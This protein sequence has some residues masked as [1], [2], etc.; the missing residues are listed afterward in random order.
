M[1]RSI[2]ALVAL[3]LT[4]V[5]CV[6]A[7]CS[8]PVVPAVN[9]GKQ[10][11]QVALPVEIE[12]TDYADFT[13]RTAAVNSVEVRAR[14]DG[15]LDSVHFKAGSLVKK[16][17]VLFVI[18]Q[19][20][21]ARE[22]NR[23]KAQLEQA[24]AEYQSALT[25]IESAEA[26]KARADAVLENARLRLDRVAKLLTRGAMTQEEFDERKSEFLK[27]EADVRNDIAGIASAKA[28]VVSAKAAEASASAAVAIA[29]L[30]LDYTTVTAPVSGRISRN[31]ASAGNLIQAGQSGGGT[32]LTTIVS[33]DPMYAYFDVDERTVLRVKQLIREGK[34]KMPDEVEIPVW[35][36][37]ANEKGYPHR[38]T[39]DF[40]DNQV[41]P[42][43]GTLRV[44]GVFANEDESLSPGYFARVRVPI[45]SPHKALL[46]TERALDTDQGQKIVYVVDRDNKVVALP[47]RLGALHDGLREITEG[48]QPGER[49]IVN[50]LQQVRPGMTAEPQMR[51]NAREKGGSTARDL[52]AKC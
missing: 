42:K 50:G 26:A 7:G 40:I 2:N 39:I 37:L 30:N 32:L 44:R 49:V 12:V 23:A 4:A 15:Y 22:L 25:Q 24:R 11:V 9:Q 27:G 17:D 18:D 1:T 36:G 51:P 8:G 38:G 13:S 6:T 52:R 31:L 5:L 3:G 46:V 20:P 10:S 28:A 16:G 14:V 35:L 43:T 34:A 19:R 41:N 29:E 48:L 45:G 33:V 21:F 47:V